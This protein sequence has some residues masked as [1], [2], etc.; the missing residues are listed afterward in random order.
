V[1]KFLEQEIYTLKRCSK[2]HSKRERK[3]R[4]KK[5]L[6]IENYRGGNGNERV[7]HICTDRKYVSVLHIC[8]SL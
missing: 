1:G 8:V 7:I 6:S 3:E 2:Q 5:T 4:K